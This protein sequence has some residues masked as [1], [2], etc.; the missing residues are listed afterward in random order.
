[1]LLAIFGVCVITILLCSLWIEHKTE[2]TLPD[3]T[4]PFAVGRAVYDWT[5]AETV[6]SL[7]PMPGAKRE[8]LVWIWYPAEAQ[9]SAAGT[10][11]LPTE[12]RT[13]VEHDRGPFI[14]FLTRDLA[15]VHAHSWPN[16]AVSTQQRSYPMVIMRAGASLEV[17]NFTTLAEDLASHGYVVIGFDAPYRSRVVVFPDG[18]V[19]KRLPQ[20]D[21]ERCL[22]RAGQEQERCA[23][24]LQNAWTSD[25]AFV[26]DRLT[27]LNATDPS[28]SLTPDTDHRPMMNAWFAASAE[29][30]RKGRRFLDYLQLEV[31]RHGE[32]PEQLKDSVLKGFGSRFLD[33]LNQP[34]STITPDALLL[35]DQLLRHEKTFNLP[36]PIR[37][38]QAQKGPELI[39]DPRQS[40]RATLNLIELMK[41]FFNDLRQIN[42]GAREDGIRVSAGD[43]PPRH[44]SSATRAL[45]RAVAWYQHLVTNEL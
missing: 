35:V 6:D 43:S 1:V 33:L 13:T 19:I 42:H 34:K 20:N 38:P 5:D 39:L 29:D 36:L 14:R 44:F 24:K 31:E 4:G 8:L 45:H 12:L 32:V 23:D 22:E 30:F 25:T 7:A 41:E 10:G 18:R 26:L 17:W 28:G 37:A 9:Q 27:A 16:A 2:I 40:L 11:Y 21:P 3:P 15:K